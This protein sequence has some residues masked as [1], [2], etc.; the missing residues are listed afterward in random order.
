VK[1]FFGYVVFMEYKTK[2]NG[3]LNDLFTFGY[4]AKT[5]GRTINYKNGY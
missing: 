5:E 2:M 1:G 4:G 3:N